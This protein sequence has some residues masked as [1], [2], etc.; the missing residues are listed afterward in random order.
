MS[1]VFLGD[2]IFFRTYP[3]RPQWIETLLYKEELY[4]EELLW[5]GDVD[6]DDW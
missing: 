5:V 3:R 2:W 6:E 4:K 1:C